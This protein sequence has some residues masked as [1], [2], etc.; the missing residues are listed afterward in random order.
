MLASF[1]TS[2]MN[3]C[4]FSACVYPL[5]ISR[6]EIIFSLAVTQ[7]EQTVVAV[8]IQR[9]FII[10]G[11]IVSGLVLFISGWIF[12]VTGCLFHVYKNTILLLN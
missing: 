8:S 4:R 12:R 9:I 5:F 10:S 6:K 1:K 11:L 7:T 3:I 2:S